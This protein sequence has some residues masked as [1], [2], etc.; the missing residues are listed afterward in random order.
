MTR[1][2]RGNFVDSEGVATEP[3]KIVVKDARQLSPQ[4]TMNLAR[5]GF[6]LL[7]NTVPSYD[8]LDHQEV[9]TR[10]YRDCE[11]IVA[12]ATGG[13]VWAFDH[14]IRSAGGLAEKRRV[15]GGQDVQG[16]AH[17]VHGDYTLRSARDRLIQLTEASSVN[18]T[19]RQVV[20][21]G[22]GLIPKDAANPALNDG[23]RFAIINVWRNIEAEPVATHP[24][25]LCDGQ[26]VQPEDL[27][28]FEIHMPDRVGENYWAK[29]DKRHLFYCYPA[30]TR[31]E[32]LLIKQWDSA[33]LLAQSRGAKA[34]YMADGPCTFSFHS[35]FYDA[36]TPKD[37]PDRWSIEVRCMVLY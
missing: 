36:Q 4:N 2:D 26:S 13:K 32:A 29:Y 19:L 12:E 17:I 14:N 1:D 25:A 28:V 20:P 22:Q 37:A 27:V 3:H 9:I 8:F 18:D 24:L 21:E 33:G 16:P 34:D 30:M 11:E 35:A 23:G 5:N 7:E 10:Y 31:S 15:K 6:E